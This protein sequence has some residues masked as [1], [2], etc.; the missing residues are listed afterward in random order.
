MV[1]FDFIISSSDNSKNHQ[2]FP[3]NALAPAI[4]MDLSSTWKVGWEFSRPSWNSKRYE[5]RLIALAY[6][7]FDAY[8][9]CPLSD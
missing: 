1:S 7:Y 3:G 9:M 5:T 4:K 6:K 2:L 8:S